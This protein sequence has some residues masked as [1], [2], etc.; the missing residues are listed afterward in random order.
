MIELSSFRILYLLLFVNVKVTILILYIIKV[1]G[2]DYHEYCNIHDIK[3]KETRP[4]MERGMS[5][6]RLFLSR[7]IWDLWKLWSMDHRLVGAGWKGKFF[8]GD[9]EDV[10]PCDGIATV[11]I[12]DKK[13]SVRYIEEHSYVSHEEDK[14]K[15]VGETY[16]LRIPVSEG[17]SK[18]VIESRAMEKFFRELC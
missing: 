6:L 7:R 4:Y 2:D 1:K 16:Y 9:T 15:K 5:I 17:D 14:D 8:K 10:S 18:E 12:E 11:A 13:P 3:R